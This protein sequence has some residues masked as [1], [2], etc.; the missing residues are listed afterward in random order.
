MQHGTNTLEHHWMPFTAN[1]DF[2]ADPRLLVKAK[3]VHYWDHKGNRLLDGVSGLFCCNAGHGRPE[4]VEAVAQALAEL[5]Y[6]PNF[7]V[8]SPASFE[9]ARRI[10][11][12]TPGDLDYVFF[13]GSG[14][15]SI[16]TS[17]KIAM[18]Y[19]GA[20]GEGQRTRFVSRERAYHGVDMG[21]TSLA[22]IVKNQQ[23]YPVRLPGVVHMRHTRLDGNRFTRGQAETGAELAED[24]QRFVDLYGADTIAACYVEPIAGSIGCYVPP[25]GYLER[26]R[27]ICDAYGILLVFDEVIC[28]FGR[29]G[30]AFGGHSFGVVP[31]I[32]TMAKAITNGAQPLGAVAVR[33]SVYRAIVDTAPEG[34]VELFHGHTYSGHPVACAAGLATLDIYER[35]GL[36]ERAAALSPR[37]LDGLFALRDLPG[38]ADIRGYGLLGAIDLEP[39]G[40]PGKRGYETLKRLFAAG[41]LL[42]YTGDT[43]V[44]SPPLVSSEDDIDAMFG[45]LREVLATA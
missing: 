33:E 25:K 6:A 2:K 38:I 35:E 32:M 8:G 31:D 9:L 44:L 1:R 30:K 21:G 17:L 42:K 40:A 12:I 23:A 43:A 18:A 22:G 13:T 37:F 11:A 34:A 7:Q 36:F 14:S 41:L 26:L 29:T 19:H 10:A 39:A 16:D 15:E 45:I 27:E 5:D 4:I 3:G 20:R 24:L 28:G